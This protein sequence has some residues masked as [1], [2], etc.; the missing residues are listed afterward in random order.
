MTAI[1]TD[2]VS[3]P[4]PAP[5]E[6]V[7]WR[8]LEHRLHGRLYL[9]E[10]DG[11]EVVRRA[12]NLRA[13]HRPAG[14][15]VA[16]DTDD[17]RRSIEFATGHRLGVGV[18]A[19]GH[20]TGTP[21]DESGL[22]VN[23]SRLQR[24]AVRGGSRTALVAAGARWQQVS[25]AA[26]PLGL[27]GLAG[28]SPNTGVVGYSLGGG[29]GWLGRKF[30][31]ASGS[32]TRAEI[33]TAG[34]ERRIVSVD[35]ESEL[36]WGLRG[37]TGNFGIVTGLGFRLHPVARVYAGNL[38]YPL[39]R[40]ADVLGFFAQWTRG[41]PDDL[42][43]AVT[44]RK[45]PPIPTVPEPMR[46][47]SFVAVRGC[48]SGD[49]AAGAAV[50]NRARA[51]LGPATVDT[52]ATIPAA[53]LAQLSLDPVDPLPV[54]NHSA[55][56]CDLTDATVDT[57]VG[58]AGPDAESPL[59]MLEIRQLGGALTGHPG[60]LS[61]MAHSTARFSLNAIGITASPELDRLVRDHLARVAREIRPFSTGANYLNFLDT[62][63]GTP[64]RVADAYSASDLRRLHRL[65][66]RIDPTDV[67]RFNRNIP[68][69]PHRNEESS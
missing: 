47:G 40:A 48:W 29:F 57:L 7:R 34:G 31:L 15:V 32:M 27:A 36:W 43:A 12:W 51:A 42:T 30:G 3:D 14:V 41:V 53:A 60:D 46:G 33:I 64:D 4:F 56:L 23:T 16:E 5:V 10:D 19:T 45:F 22:L 1:F 37:G 26:A 61:P 54:A 24:V 44:F 58:L 62:D 55:L 13:D 21:C 63:G 38:Y 50:I 8:H 6:P 17:V 2:P 59:V 28:S 25:D 9:P 69:P 68:A 49:P 52:F 18:M 11:Y 20:G 39:D 35:D 65:K 67:F 66:R